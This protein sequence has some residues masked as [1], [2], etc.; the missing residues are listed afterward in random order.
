MTSPTT[1][2]QA[3]DRAAALVGLVT[4]ST[5][6][7]TAAELCQS[8]GYAKSTVS[9]LL[10]AME[11][12]ELLRRTAD[13]AWTAG[14]LFAAYAA[15]HDADEELARAA[16]AAME[17]LGE[18]TGETVHLAV[19]RHGQVVQIAQ[20]ESTYILGSRDW[21]GVDVPPH[22]SAL[23]KVLYADEA[24]PVPEGAYER[25][26]PASLPDAAALRAELPTILGLGYATTVDELEEGLS[27]VAAPVRV[28]GRTVAAIGV[29]G[30]SARLQPDLAA[31]GRMVIRQARALEALLG[32][33]RK[34]G[35][36]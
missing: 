19:A 27:A 24:I 10:A 28:G 22:C 11:R 25:P 35:A 4:R 20:V 2:A 26:T 9:R 14:P 30:P 5:E 18:A 15:S 17:A 36:A 3:V 12:G 29:S 7:V 33:D 8:T 21:V 31:T 23:G 1:G 6:P 16:A 32:Q 34:E 13:G